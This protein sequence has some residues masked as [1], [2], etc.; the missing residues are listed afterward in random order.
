MIIEDCLID[1]DFSGAAR[2]VSEERTG[3][4]E[5]C[6]SNTTVRNAGQIGILISPAGGGVAGQ[7]I[8]AAFDNVRVQNSTFGIV[9]GDNARLMVNRSVS[10]ATARSAFWPST[11]R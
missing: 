8:D 6:I 11:P 7:R 9:I 3:G 2:G 10:R 5:L 1:C 4:G